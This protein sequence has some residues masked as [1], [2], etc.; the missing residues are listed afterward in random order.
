M[1]FELIRK[2]LRKQGGEVGARG[3]LVAIKFCSL[4]GHSQ[5]KSGL[6]ATSPSPGATSMGHQATSVC[7]GEWGQGDLQRPEQGAQ[8]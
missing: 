1:S 8:Q 7:L 4:R 3:S 5:A 6:R 2:K